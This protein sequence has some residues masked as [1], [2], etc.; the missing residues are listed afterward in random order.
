MTTRED[1]SN[2][3]FW[4]ITVMSMVV[5]AAAL[6][7][8][9]HE[10]FQ[11]A[12]NQST[13]LVH[14]AAAVSPSEAQTDYHLATWL[15]RHNTSAYLGLAKAQLAAGRADAALYSLQEAGQGSA[16]SELQ[17]RALLETGRYSAA[18]NA[19]KHLTTSSSNTRLAAIASML[20]GRAADAAMQ[21]QAIPDSSSRTE[22]S[23]AEASPI[24]LAALLHSS[25]LIAS[26]T[27]TLARQP[28]SYER[29]LLLA[30]IYYERR[31]EPALNQSQHLLQSAVSTTPSSIEARDLLA[32]VYRAQGNIRAATEQQKL[33]ALLKSG[34]L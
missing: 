20:A 7:S 28:S 13:Q 14:N 4:V 19:A 23:R 2:R 8:L 22:L 5:G 17:I 31:S 3:K 16:Q 26:A 12:R 21:I 29:D 24:A 10:V 18:A 11:L 9:V 25:S 27:I 15:D 34:A 33:V 30:R 1:E 6:A 32:N